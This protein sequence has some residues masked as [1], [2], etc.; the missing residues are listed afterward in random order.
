MPTLSW[1][2]SAWEVS[3]EATWESEMFMKGSI[4]E[5]RKPR[6]HRV[7]G[8]QSYNITLNAGILTTKIHL[9]RF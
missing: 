1:G 2:S 5:T 4:L 7:L 9:E 3:E 8:A 6:E